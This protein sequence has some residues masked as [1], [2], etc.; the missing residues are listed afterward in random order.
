[1]PAVTGSVNGHI[2]AGRAVET[3]EEVNDEKGK[4]K[5]YPLRRSD[6]TWLG[7]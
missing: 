7:L 6:P 4:A 5:N 1:M 2:K 3:F